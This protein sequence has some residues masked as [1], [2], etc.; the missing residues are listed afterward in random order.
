MNEK[1]EQTKCAVFF[2]GLGGATSL[3][4]LT[5]M[6]EDMAIEED[7]PMLQPS[8]TQLTLQPQQAQASQ[9]ELELDRE[10][11]DEAVRGVLS[12]PPV[13]T[14][15]ART[16][17]MPSQRV[18]I[19]KASFFDADMDYG[20]DASAAVVG[21]GFI[22]RSPQ[23][24]NASLFTRKLDMSLTLRAGPTSSL[25]KAPFDQTSA[26]MELDQTQPLPAS[27][28]LQPRP[29]DVDPLA[30]YVR[31]EREPKPAAQM[32]KVSTTFSLLPFFS[33]SSL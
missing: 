32:A 12:P 2:S 17:G 4:P 1:K 6:E 23:T 33:V 22:G 24:P 9:L 31:L 5:T 10:D 29:V 28:A 13:T 16:L 14:Q 27:V 18:Q 21:G 19:M 25:L 11:H 20:A 7:E 26:L 3:A 8:Q 15:L 30:H